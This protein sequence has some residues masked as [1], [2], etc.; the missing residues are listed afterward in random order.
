M[1]NRWLIFLLFVVAAAPAAAQKYPERRYI[2][3]GNREYAGERWAEAETAYRRAIETS[4]DNP[5]AQFNLG[6]VLYRQER[7]D[8]AAQAF[9]SLESP[10]A[11][12][13][14]GNV[15]FR[16]RKLQEALE[17]YK[18]AMRADPTDMDAK[19]NYAY[20]KKLM[21]QDDQQQ[22]QQ[23]SGQQEDED[24]PQPEEQ[25]NPQQEQQ[26]ASGDE[27]MSREDAAQMLDAMQ[28][29]E[30]RT[31]EKLDEKRRA[32]VVGRSRKNW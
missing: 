12:Y 9:G 20:V 26:E 2:R 29:Q 7:W 13:N 17:A 28:A 15:L 4:P 21:E 5:Q 23:N 11:H 24:E 10:A 32:A 25:Q 8:D 1:G 22:Q 31:Q 6:N 27:G 30:D 16:Q 18:N 19:F 3:E 14:T